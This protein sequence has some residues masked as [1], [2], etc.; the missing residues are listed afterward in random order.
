MNSSPN[1]HSGWWTGA[2]TIAKEVWARIIS[3]PF[4][5]PSAPACLP[6]TLRSS[7]ISTSHLSSLILG[8][9]PPGCLLLWGPFH[10]SSLHSKL[11]GCG[12]FESF[13]GLNNCCY[14]E[15]LLFAVVGP[16]GFCSRA[17]VETTRCSE[18]LQGLTFHYWRA[19]QADCIYKAFIYS[20][21]I[22]FLHFVWFS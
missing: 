22:L 5:C 17:R 11:C 14:G 19:Y 3:E 6:F 18:C 12:C 4:S 15:I 10:A 7:I 13:E 8:L 9:E 20:F 1:C 16:L 21:V 2:Q